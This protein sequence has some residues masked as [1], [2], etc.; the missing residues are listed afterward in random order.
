LI[1]LTFKRGEF[2]GKGFRQALHDMANELI[3]L[4][5]K[6][7]PH[8]KLSEIEDNILT[9][10]GEIHVPMDLPRR[11]TVVRLNDSWL[12]VFS[13]LAM[14]EPAPTQQRRRGMQ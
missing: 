6:V 9:V 3:S 5:W 13:A 14:R 7:L 4:Q 11:M 12:V 1:Q 8:G 2:I 10:T